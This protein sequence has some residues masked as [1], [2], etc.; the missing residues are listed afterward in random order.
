LMGSTLTRNQREITD[1]GKTHFK[2]QVPTLTLFGEKDGLMRIT[3]GAEAVWH[4]HK[5]IESAQVGKFPVV[6]IEGLNHA[7]FM[8]KRLLTKFVKEHDL[9]QEIE[10]LEGHKQIA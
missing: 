2:Y 6:V 3:R 10:E 5:N 1:D 8:S 4:Q 7:G 9:N